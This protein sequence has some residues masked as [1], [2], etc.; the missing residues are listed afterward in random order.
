MSDADGDDVWTISIDFPANTS[1]DYTFL[2]G[3]CADWSC[4]ENIGGQ[5]CAVAPYND[6]HI[7]LGTEDV[8]VNACFAVCGDGTCDELEPP[9]TYSANFEIGGGDHSCGQINVQGSWDWGN[10]WAAQL[11]DV[12]GDGVYSGSLDAGIQLFDGASYEYLFLCVDT[13]VF[14]WWNDIFANS[15]AINAPMGLECD[16]NPDDSYGN[17]GFTVNG[18]DEMLH[19]VPEVAKQ[20][21]HPPNYLLW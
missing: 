13:T 3:N 19:T 12:D 2:N 18:A 8:T 7:D 21:V 9:T 11:T 15:T 5:E 6:R 10:G 1:S 20:R 16:F 17:Y 4:K 14:E